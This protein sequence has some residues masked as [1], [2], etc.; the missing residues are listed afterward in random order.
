MMLLNGG[1]TRTQGEEFGFIVQ[2]M[3]KYVRWTMCFLEWSD[4]CIEIRD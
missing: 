4:V 1:G 2:I 3:I